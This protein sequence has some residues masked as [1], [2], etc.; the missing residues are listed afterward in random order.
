MPARIKTEILINA[1]VRRNTRIEDFMQE[2]VACVV[3]SFGLPVCVSVFLL[4]I[5]N[6]VGVVPAYAQAAA[7]GTINGYVRDPT[8]AAV[9][10]VT[11]TA[12]MMEQQAVRTTTTNSEGF[13]TFLAM[14]PGTYQLTFEASG[15]N[16]SLRT[17]L[18]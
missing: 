16:R 13:Y 15:F 9:P 8:A 4:S 1:V 6:A 17:G 10:A 5:H 2:K 18:E 7:T 14:P 11:V 3:S 12:K